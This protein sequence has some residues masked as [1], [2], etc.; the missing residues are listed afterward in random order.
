MNFKDIEDGRSYHRQIAAS[1]SPFTSFKYDKGYDAEMFDIGTTDIYWKF[2]NSEEKYVITG[3]QS[4]SNDVEVP[5][6]ITMGTSGEVSINVDEV[7]NVTQDIYLTDKVEGNSYKITNSIATLTL[8][9]GIYSDRFV[10]AFKSTGSLSVNDDIINTFTNIYVDQKNNHINITKKQ[11][12]E[13]NKVQLFNLLGKQ[14]ASWKIKE[15]RE[16]YQ[17]KIKRKLPTGV[18]IVKLNSDKR[19][20]NKKVIIE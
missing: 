2:P 20:S 6:E 9:Q 5:L 1:F 3:V 15:Q 8:D 17:L 7:K 16:K 11:E 4:I 13:I 19:K 12:I 18:Y 14:V 10:L